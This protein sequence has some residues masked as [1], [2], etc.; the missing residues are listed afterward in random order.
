MFTSIK[1]Y[2]Y[3][4]II[5]A[6]LGGGF[7]LGLQIGEGEMNA[8]KVKY[9]EAQILAVTNALKQRDLEDVRKDRLAKEQVQKQQRILDQTKARLNEIS[10]Y[11]N[12]S[13]IP[14]GVIRLHDSI[15]LNKSP[16]QL[17]LPSGQSNSSCSGVRSSQLMATVLNNYSKFKQNAS[18]LDGLSEFWQKH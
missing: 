4:A 16:D 8:L 9:E 11:V 12:D 5:A 18:Q 6:L 3:L 7:Y 17:P 13:C 15:I 10:K 2:I 1:L 14:W